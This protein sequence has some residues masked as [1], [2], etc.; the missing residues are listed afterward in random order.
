[1]YDGGTL[2]ICPAS[3]LKQWETEINS[4]VKR[5]TLSVVLHHGNSREYKARR[6]ARN[7]IVIT[8]YHVAL[9]ENK[10]KSCLYEIKWNRIILDEAHVTRNHKSLTSIAVCALEAKYRWALSGTPIQACIIYIY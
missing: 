1:M 7:D 6:L 9:N 5:N 4:R 10:K 2:I 8:T 3:L